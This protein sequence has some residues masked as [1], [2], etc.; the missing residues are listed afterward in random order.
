VKVSVK[1]SPETVAEMIG[2]VS[3]LGG[4]GSGQSTDAVPVSEQVAGDGD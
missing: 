2:G 3:L 4:C 1:V